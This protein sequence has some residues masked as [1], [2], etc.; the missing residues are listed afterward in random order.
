[1]TLAERDEGEIQSL[2]LGNYL[3]A[4]LHQFGSITLTRQ[5]RQWRDASDDDIEEI[6]ATIAGALSKKMKYGILSSD[7]TSLHEKKP[8]ATFRETL[9]FLRSWSRRSEFHTE[10][11]EK[12]FYLHLAKEDGETL[13]ISGKITRPLRYEGQCRRHL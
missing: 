12:A 8:H 1:M 6:S 2:D 11:L 4:G 10:A 9:T 5:Q 3:H 7:A 13:T